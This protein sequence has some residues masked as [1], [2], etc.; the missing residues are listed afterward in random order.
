MWFL[1]P[2]HPDTLPPLLGLRVVSV[3]R[4]G[5]CIY[6]IAAFPHFPTAAV[7][8]V[9]ECCRRFV[10]HDGVCKLRFC[11]PLAVVTH[12]TCVS[13]TAVDGVRGI[14]LT[15]PR[16]PDIREGVAAYPLASAFGSRLNAAGLRLYISMWLIVRLAA[17]PLF[18]YFYLFYIWLVSY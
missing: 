15:D 4:L 18:W 1:L 7:G 5:V 10:F 12:C 11:A 14:I 17:R 13:I 3:E 16:S 9:G 8:A 2:L 6:L